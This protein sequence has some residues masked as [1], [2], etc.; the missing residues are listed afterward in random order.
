M[1]Q[2][3]NDLN[4]IENYK[5]FDLNEILESIKRKK[6]IFFSIATSV[7]FFS[8]CYAF[9]RKPIW[10]G[11]FQI[12]LNQTQQTTP[13][14]SVLDSL[15]VM[16]FGIPTSN[17][18]S[19]N[20]EV[21]ILQSPAVLKPVFDFV[22]DQ[23]EKKGEV[24]SNFRFNDWSQQISISLKPKTFVLD[25]Y[26]RDENKDLI[27]PV[28]NRISDAYKDYPDRDKNKN[29]SKSIKYFEDQISYYLDLN[30][31]SFRKYIDFAL[32]NDL[33]I[34]QTSASRIFNADPVFK[35][36]KEIEYNTLKLNE[37]ENINVEKYNDKILPLNLYIPD[38][39][40]FQEMSTLVKNNLYTLMIKRQ[41]F[42]EEDR[43]IKDLKNSIKNLNHTMHRNAKDYLKQKISINENR[44][45]LITKP[46]N[47][48][49]RAK[50]LQRE[51]VRLENI[52]NNLENNKQML[53]IQLSKNNS[54][55][56]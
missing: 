21:E 7:L 18:I 38:S 36:K 42:T 16:G 2:N 40:D 9:T 53:S 31:K 35:L 3:K 12:V 47:V 13:S 29:I 22:K 19:L 37:L 54:T 8:F 4:N 39:P 6:K 55:W 24:K 41:S 34:L 30:A 17:R 15:G 46:K 43:V 52:I 51:I 10:E 48:L 44:L 14:D 23:Q 45:K 25:F 26:Y 49:I 33:T 32:E 50:E 20:T 28:I 56:E 5:E 11:K 27:L 1:G